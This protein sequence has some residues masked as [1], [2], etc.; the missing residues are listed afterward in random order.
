MSTSD[1]VKDILVNEGGYRLLPQPMKLGRNAFEFAHALVG[2]DTANDL[3]VVVEVKPETSDDLIVR[4][5]LGLTRALDVLRSRR[6]VTAVLTSGPTKADTLRAISRV[7][8]VLP[9]GS[10]QG[11]KA[12]EIIRDWLSVLLPLAKA[13]ENEIVLDWLGE[14][15]PHLPANDQTVEIFLGAAADGGEAVEEALADAVRVVI[16]PVLAEGE[17]D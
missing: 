17:E 7:C 10:P 3:V 9:V 11:P 8:R 13:E 1:S 6:S 16:E 5:I 12:E 4:N 15:R 14:L 2:T